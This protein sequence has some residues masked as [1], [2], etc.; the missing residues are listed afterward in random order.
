MG[1]RYDRRGGCP[2]LGGGGGGTLPPG[3]GSRRPPQP[4]STTSSRQVGRS[5]NARGDWSRG[6][7]RGPRGDYFEGGRSSSRRGNATYDM[8]NGRRYV[9]RG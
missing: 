8:G 1:D 5:D 9:V 3:D 2:P 6:G 4:A 7:P